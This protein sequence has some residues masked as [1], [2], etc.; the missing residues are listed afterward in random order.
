MIYWI[1]IILLAP[2]VLLVLVIL[3]CYL[4]IGWRGA[5]RVF[6]DPEV[7]PLRTTALVL[8]TARL[9]SQGGENLYFTARME[10]AAA[11]YMHTKPRRLILSGA[12]RV[13]ARQTESAS[14]EADC[15]RRGIPPENLVQDPRGY[16]TWDSMWICLHEFGCTDPVVVSQRFHV[17]RAVFIGR[18]MG[19]D[20]VG[21]TAARVGGWVGVRMFGRECLARVKCVLD[22]VLLHPAPVYQRQRHRSHLQN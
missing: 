4:W 20:P 12:D 1:I 7:L 8:G 2:P 3:G 15:L 21:F 22:C 11:L 6:S 14:M 13:A 16:R 17:S 5:S 18:H 19:M 9:T 10:A